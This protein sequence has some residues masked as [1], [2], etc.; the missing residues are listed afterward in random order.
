MSENLNNDQIISADFEVSTEL[1]I[2]LGSVYQ[3]SSVDSLSELSDVAIDISTLANGNSL[4]YDSTSGKWTNG[5]VAPGADDLSEL[6]DVSITTPSNDQILRYNSTSGKWVNS[7]ESAGPSDLNGLDDVSITSP[8]A[9]QIL[10]YDSISEKWI[11]SEITPGASDLSDLGDVAI[12]SP[13]NDQIL[14]YNSTSGKWVNSA[15]ES[16]WTDIAGTLTAGQTSITLS[17]AVITTNSMVEIFTPNGTEWNSITVA[18]GSVTVTF[19][20]QSSD[21]VVIARITQWHG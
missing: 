17:D 10:K 16:A 7:T 20:A 2:Q 1:D 11:N 3:G 12:S 14:K 6:G 21:M 19:D 8:S 5:E 15:E 9:D 18:T 4:I 13:S